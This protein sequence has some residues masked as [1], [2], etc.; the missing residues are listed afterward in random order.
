MIKQLSLTNWKSISHAQLYVDPLTFIIGTNAAGKSN[1]IDAMAFLNLIAQSK[2]LSDFSEK[3]IR[4]G[5]E[6]VIR[7]G[8]TQCTLKIILLIGK[9]EYTY[10]ITFGLEGK[11]LLVCG[12]SLIVKTSTGKENV[13][14]YTDAVETTTNQI[15]AR[16]Q[17]DKKGPRKGLDVRR[18]ISILSQVATL[19][20]LKSI[21][22]RADAVCG[23][24]LSIFVL[25]P[26][27]E[28]MR[29]YTPLADR[30]AS[31]GSNIAG[32]IA[33]MSEEGKEQ[34]ETELTNYVRPL[35]ER[36][37]IRIWAEPV[38][39][40]K[41]DAMLYC[42]EEW[43]PGS[44]A[45]FDARYMSDGT[46]RFVAIVSAL[47]TMPEGST[48]VVEEI[49]NGLHPSRT[50][51]LVIALKEIGEKRNIDIIC[52]THNPVLIDALGPHMLPF[53]SYVTRSTET[54]A[55]E[56]KLL[57]EVPHLLKLLSN[58]T[59]GGIMTNGLLSPRLK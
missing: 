9:D 5:I 21:K 6:G 19:N 27:P 40:F 54:G 13:L 10:E 34:F 22:D 56:I 58:Y 33:G 41:T 24:L 23:A 42:E 31:D 52:T 17:K 8:E 57:E 2:R 25:D 30:L 11:E 12:E 43:V 45:V 51:E 50:G 37:L 4:G 26:K 46:L 7:R 36:D 59:P 16:F 35:P 15:T 44:K 53:I 18:D 3:E 1:I 38:G 28:K 20:V 14:F 49:D 32:V 47:L 29:D 48:I 55:S 39:L